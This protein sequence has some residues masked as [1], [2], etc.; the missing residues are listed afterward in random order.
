V[1]AITIPLKLGRDL[2]ALVETAV[3]NQQL[4]NQGYFAEQDFITKQASL[5]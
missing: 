5:L 3:L 2:T 4:R 1:P